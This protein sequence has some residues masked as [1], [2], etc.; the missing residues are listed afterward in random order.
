MRR[1]GARAL[2]VMLAGCTRPEVPPMREVET[3]CPPVSYGKTGLPL[4][5]PVATSA[6]AYLRAGPGTDFPPLAEIDAGAPLTLTGE[7]G[8]WRLA[9]SEDGQR[10]WVHARRLTGPRRRAEQQRDTDDSSGTDAKL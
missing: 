2:L 8:Y 4:P 6:A 5:R 10:G 9:E 3:A 7:C 1:V